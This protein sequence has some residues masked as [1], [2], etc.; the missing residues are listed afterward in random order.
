[1]PLKKNMVV[2]A[3]KK[4]EKTV[5]EHLKKN[6]EEVFL[7]NDILEALKEEKLFFP[8]IK[9]GERVTSITAALYSLCRKKKAENHIFEGREYFGVKE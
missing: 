2:A 1:M 4:I 7:V 9:W 5:Y 8:E 3:E 6:N